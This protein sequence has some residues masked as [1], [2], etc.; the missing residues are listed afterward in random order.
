M[1]RLLFGPGHLDSSVMLGAAAAATHR[2]VSLAAV[3][4]VIIV[5]ADACQPQHGVSVFH[6]LC[7]GLIQ[8]HKH[9][10][11][12]ISAFLFHL[13]RCLISSTPLLSLPQTPHSCLS[14]CRSVSLCTCLSLIPLDVLEVWAPKLLYL[15][16]RYTY[17]QHN[18]T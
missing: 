12:L 1:R 5:R 17:R 7:L 4:V 15:G 8:T 10:P 2:P 11:H 18:V 9:V 16:E 13:I 6:Q 14:L 3:C